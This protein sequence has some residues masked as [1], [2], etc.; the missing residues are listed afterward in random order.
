MPIKSQD[1][2]ADVSEGPTLARLYGEPIDQQYAHAAC[3][4]QKSKTKA[5]GA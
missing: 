4:E 3:Y 2:F 1:N 5:S